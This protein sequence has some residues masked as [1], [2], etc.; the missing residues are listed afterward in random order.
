MNVERRVPDIEIERLALGELE[1]ER[2]AKLR[3]L[4][5]QEQGGIAR[6]E[7]I[8][9]STE[10]ILTQYPPHLMAVQIKDRAVR[11]KN[12][13]PT[14]SR[15]LFAVPALTTAAAAIALVWFLVPTTTTNDAEHYYGVKGSKDAALFVFRKV[16]S[17]EEL[18]KPGTEVRAGDVLQIKYAARGAAHGVILSVDGRG[19]VTLHSPSTAN[20]STALEKGK[21]HALDFSYELDDAPG[22]ER[23]FFVTSDNPIAVPVVI[24]AGRK[25]GAKQSGVL[26]LPRDLAQS[27][28]LLKKK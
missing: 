9:S 8:Q 2:E 3:Q 5:E 24:T 21:A 28:F 23:F 12:A 27:D 4:L 6:L 14:R 17:D 16:A 20:N 13:R 1:P 26:D 11:T 10:E 15:A 7:E 18:L 19:T 22:F 25:L